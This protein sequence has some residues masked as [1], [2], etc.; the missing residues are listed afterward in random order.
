MHLLLVLFY[1][2]V[3]SCR[4]VAAS[5]IRG[6]DSPPDCHSL[7]LLLW[8]TSKPERVCRLEKGYCMLLYKNFSNAS[9]LSVNC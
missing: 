4:A 6:S 5:V 9:S 2:G 1:V 3:D 7:P 8:T